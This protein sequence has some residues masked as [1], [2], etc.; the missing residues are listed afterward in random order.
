MSVKK[1]QVIDSE[2]DENDDWLHS[3]PVKTYSINS[4]ILF[5]VVHCSIISQK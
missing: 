4:S 2:T 1:I 3:V 5:D